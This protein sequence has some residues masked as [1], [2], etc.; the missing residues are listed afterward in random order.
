MSFEGEENKKYE[1]LS[2][3]LFNLINEAICEATNSAAEALSAT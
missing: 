3:S 1:D 2:D